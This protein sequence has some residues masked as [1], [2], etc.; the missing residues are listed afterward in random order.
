MHVL[1]EKEGYYASPG[2]RVHPQFVKN[3]LGSNGTD[4]SQG[5]QDCPFATPS[6]LYPFIPGKKKC[7]TVP[8]LYFFLNWLPLTKTKW[9]TPP[10]TTKTRHPTPHAHL[11]PID[12]TPIISR[13]LRTVIIFLYWTL[14]ILSNILNIKWKRMKHNI[15]IYIFRLHVF[16]IVSAK[17]PT[18]GRKWAWGIGCRVLVVRRRCL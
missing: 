12:L 18:I 14:T 3:H 1:W 9:Q 15:Y 4:F 7:T 13:E 2:L 17:N 11:R 5:C 16:P 10:P 6:T 8:R